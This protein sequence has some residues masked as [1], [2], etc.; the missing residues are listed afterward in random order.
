[1][2]KFYCGNNMKKSLIPITFWTLVGIFLVIV[3][4]F[5]IP[6]VRNFFKGSLLFLL[7][8]LVFFFPG[9][10]LDNLDSERG[11]KRKTE[12]VFNINRSFFGRILCQYLFTQYYLWIVYLFVWPGL[13]AKDWRGG[14]TSF[15][16]FSDYCLSPGVFS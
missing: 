2:M 11:S 3:S 1:M 16:L 9:H 4:E 8:A 12:E 7:P 10:R 14:R 15:F 5:F 6:V 13:L